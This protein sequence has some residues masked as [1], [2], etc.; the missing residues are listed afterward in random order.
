MVKLNQ[1]DAHDRLRFQ[2]V[3]A[4]DC[5]A[6]VLRSIWP[7]RANGPDAC[8]YLSMTAF[9]IHKAMQNHVSG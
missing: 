3:D 2:H 9:Q 1:R 8:E 6:E 4:E 5:H 7:A